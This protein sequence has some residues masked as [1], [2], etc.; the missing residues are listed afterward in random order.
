MISANSA[1]KLSISKPSNLQGIDNLMD[2][3]VRHAAVEGR[4]KIIIGGQLDYIEA[5]RDHVKKRGYTAFTL[6]RKSAVSSYLLE[7]SW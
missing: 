5:V 2:S 6:P 1:A 4:R 3:M 7:I